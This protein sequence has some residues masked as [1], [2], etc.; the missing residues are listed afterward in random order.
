MLLYMLGCTTHVQRDLF[1][2]KE[3]YPKRPNV[4]VWKIAPSHVVH[5]KRDMS[6]LDLK[7]SQTKEVWKETYKSTTKEF[8]LKKRPAK[9][10][11]VCDVKKR[12]AKETWVCDVK[13]R[14][15][16]RRDLQR[17]PHTTRASLTDK[18]ETSKRDLQ[19][20]CKETYKSTT[21]LKKSPITEPWTLQGPLS[22]RLDLDFKKRPTQE[23]W[24][25][26]LQKYY[27]PEK[28]PDERSL[29][30]ARA[31][32]IP[33]GLRLEK[34]THT[35]NVKKRPTKVLQTWKRARWKISGHCKGLSRA[36]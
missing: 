31:S 21:D 10:T 2:S 36:D 12:P 17:S 28:E 3:T 19:K 26:G 27:R 35:R 18:T 30:T 25:T 23:I 34:V 6:M 24:K 1:E 5:V 7:K 22:Y 4:Y 16:S 15:F 14:P 32:L 29:D 11:W 20:K 33:T 8:Y 13:K 9:E